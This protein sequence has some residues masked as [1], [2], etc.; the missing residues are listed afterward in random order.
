M[1]TPIESP[2][3]MG[4][5]N[6]FGNKAEW[7][8][9]YF[10]KEKADYIWRS[11]MPDGTERQIQGMKSSGSLYAKSVVH[12]RFMDIVTARDGGSQTSNYYDNFYTTSGLFHVVCR[13][14][15]QGGAHADGGVLYASAGHDSADIYVGIGSR[16]AFRGTI[17]EASSVSQFLS[18]S[19]IA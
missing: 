1:R 5:E 12:G 10:N 19:M 18:I 11:V 2:V 6:W 14:S 3:C 15:Y 4:Y 16:L 7:M 9:V 8:E 17:K 13:S